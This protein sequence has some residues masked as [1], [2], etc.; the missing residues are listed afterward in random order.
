MN[1]RLRPINI[2]INFSHKILSCIWKSCEKIG[3]TKINI[4]DSGI[5]FEFDKNNYLTIHQSGHKGNLGLA[6][7]YDDYGNLEII[8]KY[9]DTH[10]WDKVNNKFKD[11]LDLIENCVNSNK[12]TP[13]SG[14][15]LNFE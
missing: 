10:F 4:K 3:L 5:Y 11:L 9:N 7:S 8:K 2:I 12:S 6:I 15:R 1:I 14:G 13:V